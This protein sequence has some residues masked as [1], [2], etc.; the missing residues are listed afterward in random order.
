MRSV[1]A[2][3]VVGVFL[4]VQS[5][6]GQAATIDREASRIQKHAL[7][8]ARSGNHKAAL[9]LLE[10]LLARYPDHYPFQRDAI[11]IASW[12]KDCALVVKLYNGIAPANRNHP[13]VLLPVAE[14]LRQQNRVR[15][16]IR[17]LESGQ[18]ANP[19][20]KAIEKALADAHQELDDQ[21][22]TTE[23]L[24]YT[25][26]SDAGNLE[27]RMEGKIW[28]EVADHTFAYARLAF[29]RAQDPAFATGELN[30]AGI[31]IDRDI[32]KFTVGADVSGD[33]AIPD[34]EGYSGRVRYRPSDK[35]NLF[36]AY[37]TFSEEVPLRGKAVGVTS[38][39]WHFDSYYHTS[40]YLWEW[41]FA[42]DA[43]DFSDTN[44]RRE[45]YS[46]VTYGL[47]LK[48][49]YEKR[50]VLELA[51][52]SN[53]LAPTVY[54]NPMSATT[55]IGGYKYWWL[56]DIS[57]YKRH[58]DDIY[59]WAG[60]YDQQNYGSAPIYGVRYQQD[61]QLDDGFSLN[62]FASVASHVYDSNRELELDV[63]LRAVY[64]LP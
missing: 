23:G 24:L 52:S 3:T 27:W 16:A 40:D 35:W 34:E 30:R 21:R 28:G 22:F 15:A 33:L 36:G 8:M 62:W 7:A 10:G 48:E 2:V 11:V 49:K 26:S 56:Y 61:Y 38:D 46:E 19:R 14:C 44:R 42:A 63:G 54:Y 17:A 20:N 47:D 4:L 25:D 9:Q 31:G 45:W 55:V 12:N 18:Q 57:K 32:G 29:V 53:T 1:T 39:Q 64:V 50:L 37:H 41:F 51:Q 13:K 5:P 60:M 6:T 58:A 59:V 43:F